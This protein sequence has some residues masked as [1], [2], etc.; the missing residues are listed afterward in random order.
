MTFDL[1]QCLKSSIITRHFGLFT[2]YAANHRAPFQV[3]ANR[4]PH[5]ILPAIFP[6]IR[7]IPAPIKS[8]FPHALL[9]CHDFFTL[10][11]SIWSTFSAPPFKNVG[12]AFPTKHGLA[13]LD[14]LSPVARHYLSSTGCKILSS[15][16]FNELHCPS[17]FSPACLLSALRKLK[18]SQPK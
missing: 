2:E 7:L 11:W 13:K 14:M 12:C 5:A 10:Y 9:P 6:A 16:H 17:E 18:H 8:S 15:L 3:V 1:E 4:E